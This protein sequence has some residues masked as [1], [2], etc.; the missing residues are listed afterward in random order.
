MGH[1]LNID[2]AQITADTQL[3]RSA[4]PRR[5]LSSLWE[6]HGR[7]LAVT[8]TVARGLANSVGAAEERR[9][10]N[11]LEHDRRDQNRHYDDAVYRRILE[12]ARAAATAWI[13]E[14]LRQPGGITEVLRTAEHDQAALAI[15]RAMPAICFTP[16]TSDNERND[17]LIV[18]EAAAYGF[19]LLASE[20]LAS[21]RHGHV[22]SW[23]ERQG[24][25]SGPLVVRLED[26][27]PARSRAPRDLDDAAFTAVLGAALPATEG[28][29]ERDRQ[30]IE[31]FID[32]L[33]R[34][35]ASACG[36]WAETALQE[37]ENLPERIRAAR[38]GFPHGTRTAE[39]RRL[40]VTER[41]A[42]TAGYQGR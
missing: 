17:R 16:T 5:F 2:P 39:E 18:G 27:M 33:K 6:L 13:R 4:A 14:E 34:G 19:R 25:V 7:A 37:E 15:A 40:A 8:P 42:R 11:L 29:L 32:V 36:R 24:H 31:R 21:I 38:A 22:N 26:A 30:A 20:N 1:G 41:A 28:S 3:L 10:Q 35:H 9:W 23:L 12:G